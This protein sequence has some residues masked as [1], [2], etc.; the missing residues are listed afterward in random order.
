MAHMKI[1]G[2]KGEKMVSPVTS[3][4]VPTPHALQSH[5]TNPGVRLPCRE[6]AKLD[7][8]ELDQPA[9]KARWL[10][11]LQ[12]PRRPPFRL[13]LQRHRALHARVAEDS[14]RANEHTL[15]NLHNLPYRGQDHEEPSSRAI[16]DQRQPSRAGKL[17]SSRVKMLSESPE[18]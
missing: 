14:R 7:L 12:R 18:Y 13:H 10:P 8:P 16:P 4:L 3:N 6:N 2:F 1:I 15:V 5:H 9:P 17:A 11:R